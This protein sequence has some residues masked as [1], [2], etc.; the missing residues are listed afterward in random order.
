MPVGA[1]LS[2][3][4]DSSVITSL[5][6]NYTDTPLRTFLVGF[7]DEE[8]DESKYQQELIKYLETE[9]A[10]ILC[11]HSDIGAALPRMIWHA[12]STILRTAPTPLMLLSGAVREAGYKVVLTGEGAD[13]IFGG[14]DLFKEAKVRRFW[15]HQPES[16]WRPRILERFYPYLKHSPTSGGAFTQRFFKQGMDSLISRFLPMVSHSI[17]WRN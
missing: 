3:G 10:H 6:K 15:S 7:E 11:K 4:L 14:Y 5:I 2:G 17:M 9:H 8:F 12:E 1:Y 16:A 13:E